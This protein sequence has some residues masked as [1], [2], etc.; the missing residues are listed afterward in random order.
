MCNQRSINSINLLGEVEEATVL[1]L[2]R[3]NII[4][5]VT[6]FSMI[7]KAVKMLNAQV[8]ALKQTNKK[9][10]Y[11]FYES[12]NR[13]SLLWDRGVGVWLE[14]KN[15]LN[16]HPALYGLFLSS[17]FSSNASIFCLKSIL[18]IINWTMANIPPTL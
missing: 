13:N 14:A 3:C 8:K 10:I 12:D 15:S 17:R 1:H 7:A 4:M 18:N 9:S 11:T 16:K 6:P 5:V 2:I